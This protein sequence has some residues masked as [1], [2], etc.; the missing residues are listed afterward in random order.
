MIPL[1][2]EL[3]QP[4]YHVTCTSTRYVAYLYVPLKQKLFHPHL[5]HVKNTSTRHAIHFYVSPQK[6]ALLSLTYNCIIVEVT[7]TWTKLAAQLYVPPKTKSLLSIY[8]FT[9]F[10]TLITSQTLQQNAYMTIILLNRILIQEINLLIE[11]L[12]LISTLCQD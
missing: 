4:H 9:F 2:W 12:T 6:K 1:K 5:Y 11:L 8:I 10:N 3:F 7:C